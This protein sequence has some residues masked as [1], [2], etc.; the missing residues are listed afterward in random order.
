MRSI[1]YVL[2]IT[3]SRD[4]WLQTGFWLV[5]GFIEHL[6]LV[7]TSKVYA[8]T[9]LHMSQITLGHTRSSHYIVFFTSRCLLTA[10]NGGLSASSGFPNY[11]C[12]SAT[13]ISQQQLTMTEPQQSSNWLTNSQ[14]NYSL[15]QKSKSKL[16]YDWRFTTKKFALAPGPMRLT[17]RPD[18][19]PAVIVLL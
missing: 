8:L 18:W 10:F 3:L 2:L 13:S 19:T 4:E 7:T 15:T 1:S 16:L 6:Q 17:T 12:A 14:T 5:I 11:S 9:V